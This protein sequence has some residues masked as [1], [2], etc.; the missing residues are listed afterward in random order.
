MA[1]RGLREER[2][3]VLVAHF[4]SARAAEIAAE[5]DR[6]VAERGVAL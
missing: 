1:K 5:T 6:R 2:D 4:G 3:A